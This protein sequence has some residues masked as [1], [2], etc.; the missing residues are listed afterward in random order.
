[1]RLTDFSPRPLICA[2]RLRELNGK[3]TTSTGGNTTDISRLKVRSGTRRLK[4]VQVVY[5]NFYQA[6]GELIDVN[7]LTAIGAVESVSPL[8]SIPL[9]FGSQRTVTLQPGTMLFPK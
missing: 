8:Y 7:A 9:L 4:G 5:G 3:S 6:T 1:M 2:T